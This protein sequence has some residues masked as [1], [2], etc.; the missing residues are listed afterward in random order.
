MANL[1]EKFIEKMKKQ[2]PESEWEA[3]FACYEKKPFKGV[4]LN[5]LRGDVSVMKRLL[6]FL[7]ASIPWEENGYYTSAERVGASPLHFAGAIYSQ[8]PSAMCA[9]P[10]L[11]V[12]EGEKVLDLCSA[13]GGKGTQ[14]AC[15]MNGK[16]V[17]VLNEPISSR[18]KILSQN[19]ERL[20]IKNAVVTN[21]YPQTLAKRFS[22]YFDKILVDAPC[23]GEGM[24]RKNAEEAL[25][26]WSEENV[27]LCAARQKEILDC[28]TQML[29]VGGWLVYS[30]CTFAE[31]EDEGQVCDYLKN[32]PEMRLIRQEK[33]YPHRVDGEGHFAALF[34]KINRT[35]QWVARLKEAKQSVTA[36]G[37]KAYREFEKEF[38]HKRFATRLY[39]NNGTI[40]ELPKEVFDWKGL[41]VLRV[42]VRLG[43]VKNGRFEPS[44]SLAMCVRKEECLRA[45]DLSVEDPRVEKYLRGETMECDL[46]NGWCLVCVEGYPLGFGKVVNGTLK[47]HLPK[48]LRIVRG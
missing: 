31:E 42:G 23:S 11:E 6:P 43:E 3:F 21:E 2:L 25:S 26:E 15:K 28:A 19:V 14:L 45:F 39:E 8:E 48:A 36:S 29:A 24:F 46:K 5:P 37:E 4:R 13:P 30:T 33:I 40:Y 47:N 17:I 27:A 32:H 38:F 1:P 9:A 22:G 44:H 10:L 16:G 7:G 35:S 12:A 18:A 34:E 20:G 41:Q